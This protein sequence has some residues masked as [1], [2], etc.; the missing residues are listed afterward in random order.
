MVVHK[1]IL[2]PLRRSFLVNWPE[3]AKGIPNCAVRTSLRQEVPEKSP[4]PE[5]KI[6]DFVGSSAELPET[7]SQFPCD[8]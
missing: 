7:Y 6:A 3:I 8:L 2:S 1:D 5:K 4:Q